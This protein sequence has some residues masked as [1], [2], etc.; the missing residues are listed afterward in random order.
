M[1][2]AVIPE[3]IPQ[4][5]VDYSVSYGTSLSNMQDSTL[6]SATVQPIGHDSKLDVV[7]EVLLKILEKDNNTYLDGRKLTDVV[8]GYNKLNDRR[9]M[10][11][12]GELT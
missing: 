7:I 4:I 8:N 3:S 2:D 12:R 9:M 10:R 5:P 11:A 1:I 6:S